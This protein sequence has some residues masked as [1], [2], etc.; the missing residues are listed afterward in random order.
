[1][2]NQLLIEEIKNHNPR[3]SYKEHLIRTLINIKKF[4]RFWDHLNAFK[5]QSFVDYAIARAC[6]TRRDLR[7]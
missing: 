5:K 2:S 4:I 3:C 6:S 1:M 7:C